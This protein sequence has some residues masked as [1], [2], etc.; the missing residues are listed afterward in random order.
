M[1]I[2]KIA[3]II[4]F[5]VLIGTILYSNTETTICNKQLTDNEFIDHM[6]THHEV[7]VYMSENHLHN[8]CHK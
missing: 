6:I 7:A 3:I 5:I 1:S 8:I 4:F 2:I